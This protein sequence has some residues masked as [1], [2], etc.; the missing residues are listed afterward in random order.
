MDARLIM[1]SLKTKTKYADLK[2]FAL[3]FNSY[4]LSAHITH[5]HA[6]AA[7]H[8]IAIE[9]RKKCL[10]D[11]HSIDGY[12]LYLVVSNTKPKKVSNDSKLTA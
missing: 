11:N 7:E 6:P 1:L 3:K 9:Q 10:H 2:Y 12:N 5:F 4:R 8:T